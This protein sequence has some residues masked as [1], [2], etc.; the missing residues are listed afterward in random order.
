MNH[1]TI[2]IA[3]VQLAAALSGNMDKFV[4]ASRKYKEALP[5]DYETLKLKTDS[6]GA[7]ALSVNGNDTIAR[8]VIARWA[9]KDRVEERL[10]HYW[11]IY[12]HGNKVVENWMRLSKN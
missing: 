4:E 3:V 10:K 11:R 1:G 6:I 7:L 5:Q 8:E 9:S 12:P 2:E